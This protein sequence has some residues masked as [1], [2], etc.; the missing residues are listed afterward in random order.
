MC[1][2]PNPKKLFGH[3]WESLKNEHSF[4]IIVVKNKNFDDMG[5][6]P[7]CFFSRF[8][9]QACMFAHLGGVIMP[10]HKSQA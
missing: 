9:I 8:L 5:L 2:V 6:F 1:K 3:I 10:S 7:F 4:Q